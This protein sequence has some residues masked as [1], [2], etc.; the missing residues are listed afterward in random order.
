FHPDDLPPLMDTWRELLVSGEPGEVEARLRR[1]DGVYRWFLIRVAPLRDETG[2]IIRWYGTSTDIEERKQAEEKLRQEEMEFRQ[3]IDAIAQTVTVLDPDGTALYANRSVLEFT[4]LT[5]EA[6]LAPDFRTVFFHPED[7]ERLRS[8]RQLALSR[9]LP[10]ENEQRARRKDGEYRWFLVQ[11]RPVKDEDGRILRWYATG[12]DI[13]DRRQAEERVQS[14]NLA[15]REE[16]DHTSMFEEIVGSSESL[17]AVLTQVAKV[18]PMD[19][20]VLILGE[21]GT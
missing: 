4:G 17:H 7:V 5:M 2:T 20:T 12:T 21:T 16:I 19:S 6:V 14:E 13:H 15:L 3:I 8:E 9:G 11:Y 1:H 18:A 10:F